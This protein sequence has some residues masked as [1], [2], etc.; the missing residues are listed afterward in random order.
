MLFSLV[1]AAAGANSDQNTI[2]TLLKQNAGEI[3]QLPDETFT[4]TAPFSIPSNTE[5][6]GSTNTILEFAPNCKIPQNVP[7]IDLTNVNNIKIT[8]IKFKGNQ[9]TQ[10]YAYSISNPNHPEQNGKKAY[11]NQINTFIFA[12]NCNNITVTGCDF[13]DNLGDGLRTSGCT[14]IEFAYNTASMGGHDVLFCL[15]T[16]GVKAHHNNIKPLVNSAIRLLD[17]SHA[18]IYRLSSK[19]Q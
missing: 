2:N 16:S 17:V 8:N 6:R 14:N 10:T 1:L 12:K 3:C 11:G 13:Y 15:R 7:M 18:R 9:A 4:I 19:I 5:L